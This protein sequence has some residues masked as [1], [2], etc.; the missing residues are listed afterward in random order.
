M[1]GKKQAQ[2]DDDEIV[3]DIARGELT[4][5]Q[6]AA[7]HGLSEPYV[8]QIARGEKR[9]ELQARIDSYVEG[10]ANQARRLGKRLASVAMGRLGALAAKDSKAPADVQR[11]AAVDILNHAIGDPSKTEVNVSQQQASPFRSDEE[12]RKFNEYMA[13]DE[14]HQ[15]D[16]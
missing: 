6:I 14:L 7:K 4:W 15:P 5:G 9:P 12:E 8:G 11:K 13:K 10:L 1:A 16:D 3:M 2:Y